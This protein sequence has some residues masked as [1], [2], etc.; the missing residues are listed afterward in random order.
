V[1]KV[2]NVSSALFVSKLTKSNDKLKQGL[3]IKSSIISSITSSKNIAKMFGVAWEIILPKGTPC[4]YISIL[5]EIN[6]DN[7]VVDS[8]HEALIGK[9]YFKMISGFTAKFFC[10]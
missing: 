7:F 2:L 9:G 10:M 3:E 6:N 4:L 5:S 8:K 1:E